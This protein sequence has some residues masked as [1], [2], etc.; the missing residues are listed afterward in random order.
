[1]RKNDFLFPC[2]S[3]RAERFS[4]VIEGRFWPST[5]NE[6]EPVQMGAALHGPSARRLRRW[7][8]KEIWQM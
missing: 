5:S 3:S 2:K 4:F 1:M 7:P 6:T 8:R